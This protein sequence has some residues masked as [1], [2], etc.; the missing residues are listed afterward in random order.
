MYWGASP[1]TCV[2]GCLNPYIKKIAVLETQ[3][4]TQAEEIAVLKRE[5]EALRN[6][7]GCVH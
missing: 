1:P 4:I 7:A 3:A 2:P 5:N 6:R